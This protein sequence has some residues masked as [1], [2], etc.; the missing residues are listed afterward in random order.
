MFAHSF[1]AVPTSKPIKKSAT[2]PSFLNKTA[3]SGYTSSALQKAAQLGAKFAKKKAQITKTQED[4]DIEEE[5]GLSNKKAEKT[6]SNTEYSNK[7][8]K[9]T[10]A[11]PKKTFYVSDSDDDSIIKSE[12]DDSFGKDG[13]RFL[14]KKPSQPIQDVSGPPDS[15]LDNSDDEIS[16][17]RSLDVAPAASRFLKKKVPSGTVEADGFS[18]STPK[19]DLFQAKKDKLSRTAPVMSSRH[20]GMSLDSD[21]EDMKEFIENLTPTSSPEV[22]PVR[23]VEKSKDIKANKNVVSYMYVSCF[24]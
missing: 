5:L 9:K 18:T 21:E 1:I 24:L 17:E 7:F 16:S 3:P 10:A 6:P 23:K 11:A 13:N 12:L 4:S 2:A 20:L 8:L 19:K 22:P 15:P 14:K